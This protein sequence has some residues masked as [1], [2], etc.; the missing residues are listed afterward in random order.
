MDVVANIRKGIKP[1]PQP[2]TGITLAPKISKEMAKVDW[3]VGADFILRKVR[4]LEERPG[5][6]STFRAER[7]GIHQVTESLLPNG[8]KN[9]GEIALIGGS[10]LIRCEDSTLEIGEVT[11]AGK[12]RM[13]GSDFARGARL[14]AGEH[15]E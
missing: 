9:V 7:I 11:P 13:T 1:T 14:V 2:N 15:F 6:W 12:K 10:L 8:L 3:G 4:A 5:T